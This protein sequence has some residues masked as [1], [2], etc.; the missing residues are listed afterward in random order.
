MDLF[1]RAQAAGR[2]EDVM[3]RFVPP[4]EK[5]YTW[6]SYRARDWSTADRGRRLDHA[7]VNEGLSPHVSAVTVLRDMRGWDVPSDHVPVVIDLNI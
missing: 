3:R 1:E 5:L 2:W 7:W 4:G 6:W